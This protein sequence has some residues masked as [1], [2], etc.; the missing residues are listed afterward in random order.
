LKN[1]A[2]K[3]LDKEKL[4]KIA[5]KNQSTSKTP[6]FISE[7][8]KIESRL[9][10]IKKTIKSLYEDKLKGIISEVDFVDLS[11]SFN[12]ER[13][14]LN[15]TYNLLQDRKKKLDCVDNGSNTLI[16]LVNNFVDFENIDKITLSKLIAKIEVFEDRK[17]KIQYKFK[18]PFE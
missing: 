7:I 3:S 9:I 18:N 16:E 13:E 17:I 10:E 5:Q 12:K 11:Q 8:T 4:I 14:S 1:I 6:E 2:E 15:K